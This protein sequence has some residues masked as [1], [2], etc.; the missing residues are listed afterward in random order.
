MLAAV[1]VPQAPAGFPGAASLSWSS[2]LPFDATLVDCLL[3]EHTRIRREL[4]SATAA[5]RAGDVAAVVRA[6]AAIRAGLRAVAKV[7]A[8][9][10]FP[11]VRRL[12]QDDELFVATL[13]ALRA[14]L[15]SLSRRLMRSLDLVESA[16]HDPVGASTLDAELD[17]VS[18]TL[19]EL[20]LA[21]GR[22]LYPLYQPE[23]AALPL[24]D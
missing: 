14:E 2:V 15:A 3:T 21:K 5:A 22:L 17:V 16:G 18:R 10:V 13:D 1:A 11:Y 23:R 4:E 6:T 9:R 20:V 8:L 19:L 12:A 7:E 24:A